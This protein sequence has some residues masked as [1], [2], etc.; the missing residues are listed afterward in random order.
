[1]LSAFLLMPAGVSIGNSPVATAL[2]SDNN[3]KV[4]MESAEAANTSHSPLRGDPKWGFRQIGL[5][6]VARNS[7]AF[8][9]DE[10]LA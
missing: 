6:N 8:L 1:M 10:G 4:A 9:K 3:L 7:G 5:A 2:L